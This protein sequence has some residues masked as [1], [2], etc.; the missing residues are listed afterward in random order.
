MTMKTAMIST[1]QG[2]RLPAVRTNCQLV[3]THDLLWA[4]LLGRLQGAVL[5]PGLGG[6][7][8]ARRLYERL[9]TL[10]TQG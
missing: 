6:V 3:A 5:T 1:P 8:E 2:A 9:M 4:T 10:Q 7:V